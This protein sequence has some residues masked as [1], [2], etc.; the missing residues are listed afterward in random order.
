MNKKTEFENDD[1]LLK[2]IQEEIANK[3]SS[4]IEMASTF[5]IMQLLHLLYLFRRNRVIMMTSGK[6]QDDPKVINY[7]IFDDVFKYAI[8]LVAKYGDW[9]CR[10]QYKDSFH[11]Y[12]PK[13]LEDF[14]KNIISINGSFDTEQLCS[15]FKIRVDSEGNKEFILLDDDLSIMLRIYGLRI[16]KF[17]ASSKEKTLLP[18]ELFIK[19][20]ERY[21]NLAELFKKG[22]SIS[23]EDYVFGLLYLNA[24]LKARF[25]NIENELHGLDAE[26]LDIQLYE[27]LKIT[28]AL[29]FTHNDLSLHLDDVF[30]NFISNNAFDPLEFD[31]NELRYHYITRNPF[32]KGQDFFM[33]SPDLIFDSLLDNIHYTLLENNL[34][35]DDYQAH[36]GAQ[37]LN[38]VAEAAAKYGY[39]LVDK[40]VDLHIGKNKIGDID[41]VLYNESREHTLLIECKCHRLPLDVYFRDRAAVESHAL[42]NKK[43]EKKVTN[44]INHLKSKNAQFKISGSWDYII[45]TLMPEPLSHKSHLMVLTVQEMEKWLES[46]PLET[47]PS[48]FFNKI[49][50]DEGVHFVHEDIKLLANAGYL[51]ALEYI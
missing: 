19:I 39:I 34:T 8:S 29:I 43:W 36:C 40:E 10:T 42:Q 50:I 22:M 24:N 4:A 11:S 26:D 30:I 41:L 48:D 35:K 13:S 38:E 32:L 46:F 7:Q 9:K 21:K 23:L 25:V 31:Q 15:V 44:R 28:D 18:E 17:A 37:F 51:S 20:L 49:Y 16:E 5:N 33:V 2:K 14:L 27:F 1:I 6:F 3:K 12:N 47:S 45:V